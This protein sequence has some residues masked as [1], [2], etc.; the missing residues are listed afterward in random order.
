M[1]L[2]GYK[3]IPGGAHF[4]ILQNTWGTGWGKD[5]Y[6]KIGMDYKFEYALAADTNIH[7]YD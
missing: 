3:A 5:G 6:V 4:W 1:N 2:V 7:L